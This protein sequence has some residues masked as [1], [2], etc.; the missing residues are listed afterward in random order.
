MRAKTHI[1]LFTSFSFFF[2]SISA[3]FADGW[4]YIRKND[5]KNARME[6]MSA[7]E[8]DSIN[9]SA[10]KGM[11]YLSETSGDD[12]SYSKYVNRLI[13]NHWDESL[14]LLFYD[15]YTGEDDKIT[16]QA[17]LSKRAKISAILS[18]ANKDYHQRK[19][20]DGQKVYDELFGKY[21]WTYI[22]PFKN[23]GGS[24]YDTK[25][26]IEAG[27]YSPDKLYK[28]ED[29]DEYKWVN[30]PARDNSGAVSF[31]DYLM[32]KSTAVYFANLFFTSPSDRTVQLRISRHDPMKLWLDDDLVYENNDNTL[33]EWDDE[34]VTL[35]LKAGTHRL[36]VKLADY[37]NG[38]RSYSY[39]DYDFSDLL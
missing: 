13:N 4:E 5:Y 36:L 27:A 2:L 38:G 23:I 32:Y 26:E 22:G 7:L 19:F 15:E 8:K 17:K 11:I 10:L 34:M 14:F 24:G 3:A 1:C 16:S 35:K 25:F 20:N 37:P 6:F 29:G 21:Q 9:A 18:K 33:F 12:L 39:T 30:P 28:D 31:S